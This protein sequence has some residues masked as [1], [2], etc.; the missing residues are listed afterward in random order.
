[1]RDFRALAVNRVYRV[2]VLGTNTTKPRDDL[3]FRKKCP[4]LLEHH[5]CF[6]N[7]ELFLSPQ[8]FLRANLLGLY[9]L[10]LLLTENLKK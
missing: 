7:N 3:L 6:A 4:W 2:N 9:I 1:M 8:L 5:I 10:Y